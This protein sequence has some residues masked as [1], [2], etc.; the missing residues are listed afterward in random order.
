[1]DIRETPLK[2]LGPIGDQSDID[3]IAEVIKSGWWGKGPKVEEFEQEFAKITKIIN[4]NLRNI[5]IKGF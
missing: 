3:A 1:M 5:F 4:I 2:V